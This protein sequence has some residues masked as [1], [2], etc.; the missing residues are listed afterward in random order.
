L[1]LRASRSLRAADAANAVSDGGTVDI[2]GAAAS[3]GE[4]VAKDRW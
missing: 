4:V 1:G 3:K 2:V